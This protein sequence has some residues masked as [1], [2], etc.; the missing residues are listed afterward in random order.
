MRLTYNW[1]KDFLD[2]KLPA[3]QLA[4]KLTMAGIEVTALEEKDGDFV[5]EVEITP[6]RPD[7]LSLIGVA[8]EAAAITH[9]RLKIPEAKR[10]TKNPKPK[11]NFKISVQDKKDCPIYTATIIKGVRVGESPAWLKKRLELVGCRSVNNVVDI[12]NYLLFE[13]GQPLHAFD[14]EKLE[15][16]TIC[17]RRAKK[18]EILVSIDGV[19]RELDPDILVIADGKNPVA[20]AGIIGGK[21]SEVSGGTKDIL[22]ESALFQAAVVRRGRQRAGVQSESSYRFERGVDP[23]GVALAAHRAA[24][25]IEKLSA[26]KLESFKSAGVPADKKRKITLKV[27]SVVN[28]LGVDISPARVK[29]ILNSL[30]LKTRSSGRDTL[31]VEAPSRR[32]DL[33]LD[34]DLIEEVARIFGYENIPTTSPR[35]RLRAASDA[36]GEMVTRIK[37]MLVG[38]GLNEVITHSLVEEGPIRILNPLSKEQAVLRPGLIPCLVSRVVYNLNQRQGYVNI[39]EIAN[40]FSS[41]DRSIREESTLGLALCG[42]KPDAALRKDKGEAGLLRIKG[43]LEVLFTR[44]GIEGHNFSNSKDLS[45]VEINVN[46]EQIGV[47]KALERGISTA[48]VKLDKII[49]GA[50]IKKRFKALPVYPQI[51]RDISLVVKKDVSVSGLLESIKEEG[52]PLLRK[53]EVVDYYTGEQIPSDCKGLTVS[54]IYRSDERTLTEGEIQPVHVAITRVLADKFGAR[55]R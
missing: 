22:L 32:Q 18:G 42:E 23:E 8:R 29:G 49:A 1:L 11:T 10:K 44:L 46:K 40:V 7:L 20:L 19:N 39:F 28:T 2:I 45:S 31:S 14:L 12:T 21:A 25:L 38:L 33:R 48:E 43:I 26:G 51:S 55:T 6:N 15:T 24:V 41:E 47:M 53:A 34:V 54:C 27:A 50:R 36:K 30:G 4:D 37:D 13:Y 3:R 52:V 16:D 35:V 9:S 17:V 5:F